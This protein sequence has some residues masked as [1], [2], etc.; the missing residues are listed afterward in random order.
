MDK[1]K[2]ELYDLAADPGESVNL[3]R[4]KPEQVERMRTLWKQYVSDNGVILPDWV[5]GY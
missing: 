1:C 3:V 2:F 5:S 4:S